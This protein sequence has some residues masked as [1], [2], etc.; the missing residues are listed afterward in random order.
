MDRNAWL[1]SDQPH[2]A[3]PGWVWWFDAAISRYLGIKNKKN[4]PFCTTFFYVQPKYQ[5]NAIFVNIE[6]FRPCL[7][8]PS[9]GASQ[10]A[11]MVRLMQKERPKSPHESL[12]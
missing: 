4:M 9:Y 7:S 11:L 2:E 1:P 8:K 3:A 12:F 10:W 6:G 5:N